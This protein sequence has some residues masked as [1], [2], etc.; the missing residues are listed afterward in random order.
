MVEPN[1]TGQP[2]VSA[3]VDD[4]QRRVDEAI[5]AAPTETE[6]VADAPPPKPSLRAR[7]TI[8]GIGCVAILGVVALCVIF[9]VL[10]AQR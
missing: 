4:Y 5:G 10:A 2:P 3:T 1:P 6:M 7:L 9:L 8:L